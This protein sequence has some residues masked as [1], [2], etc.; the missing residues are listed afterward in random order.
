MQASCVIKEG[1]D[2]LHGTLPHALNLKEKLRRSCW[3]W[4]DFSMRGDDNIAPRICRSAN[5]C[6]RRILSVPGQG[7]K[8]AEIPACLPLHPRPSAGQPLLYAMLCFPAQ[9]GYKMEVFRCRIPPSFTQSRGQKWDAKIRLP[10]LPGSRRV[11]RKGDTWRRM[12]FP[13]SDVMSLSSKSKVE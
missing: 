1:R 13:A 10:F 6:V 4:R 3:Y 5:P 7:G 2:S 11:L 12:G 8:G 9:A